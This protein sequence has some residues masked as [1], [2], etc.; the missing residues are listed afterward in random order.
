VFG[1]SIYR[2]LTNSFECIWC[3]F[4]NFC[5]DTKIEFYSMKIISRCAQNSLRPVEG[6]DISTAHFFFGDLG[7]F[8]YCWTCEN[9]ENGGASRVQFWVFMAEPLNFHYCWTFEIFDFLVCLLLNLWTFFTAEP[10]RFL[11]VY[12]WTFEILDWSVDCWTF[13]LYLLLN[14]WVSLL[15]CLLLNL[16]N[17]LYCW[18]FEILSQ[19]LYCSK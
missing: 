15:I 17:F 5:A 19:D 18:T 16:W 11:S 7:D 4:K 13:E 3:L 1:N 14:L 12:C 2:S 9:I 10:L 8:D 6:R